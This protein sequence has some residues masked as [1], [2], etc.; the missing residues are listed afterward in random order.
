MF[1]GKLKN[2]GECLGRDSFSQRLVKFGAKRNIKDL[3]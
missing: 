3:M 1:S 2:F